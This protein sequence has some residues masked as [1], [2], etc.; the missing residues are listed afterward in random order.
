MAQVIKTDIIIC[1]AGTPGLT[2][3]ALLGGIGV[4]VALIDPAPFAA[5]KKPDTR[6]AALM[7][8]SVNVLKSAGCDPQGAPLETLR[9]IDDNGKRIQTE[10]RAHEIGLPWFAIN[11]ANNALRD[12]L[13]GHV[14]A[15]KNVNC[16]IPAKLADAAVD[17]AGVMAK[18]DDGRVIRGRL[19]IGADGRESAVRRIAGIACRA[20]DF[21]QKAVTCLLSHSK[22]HDNVSTEFHRPAGPFTLVPMPGK[23]SSLV[24]V[25]KSA[26]ADAYMQGDV[27]AAIEEKSAG[28]L[29]R[30]ELSSAPA[31]WK[32]QSLQAKSLTAPRIALMAEAAHVL[33]PVG[34]QGLNLSLRDAAALAEIIADALRAG[35]DAGS[36]AVLEAYERRRRADILTR[37]AGTESLSNLMTSRTPLIKQMRRGGLRAV[38]TLPPLRRFAMQEGLAPTMDSRLA[39]GGKL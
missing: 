7:A 8:G 29:G 37:T 38:S 15:I 20:H 24:W 34:A 21:G 16:F 18:L 9:I 10:F 26:D 25:E 39:A 32:L 17:A 12:A 33:H 1:G 6:T 30:I 5:G 13:A 3:A 22:P 36:A 4:D 23:N 2:L 11:V 35:Q 19:L 27:R 31:I 14:S 28:L